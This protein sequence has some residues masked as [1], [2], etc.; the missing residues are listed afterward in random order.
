MGS[1][2]NCT[3]SWYFW[4][5]ANCEPVLKQTYGGD[6]EDK[7]CTDYISGEKRWNLDS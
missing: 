7:K 3:G 6:G 5:S 4:N 2:L 1:I